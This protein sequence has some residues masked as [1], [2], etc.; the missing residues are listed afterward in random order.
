MT[1]KYITGKLPL[2]FFMLGV[3]LFLIGILAIIMLKAEGIIAIILSIPL[4]FTRTGILIDTEKKQLK[5]YI[6]LFAYRTGK[7][8]NIDNLTHLRIIRVRQTQGM[9]VLSISRN[10]T[11]V[12]YKLIMVL[13]N[14]NIEILSGEN[15]FILLA[16]NRISSKL[17][18]KVL[19]TTLNK[20]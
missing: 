13:P 1:I 2:N 11:N 19:N 14:E 3:I 6:G 18:T 9:A 12:V 17:G 5:K 16:A 4:L 8:Q 20:D 7:W 10:E 15:D